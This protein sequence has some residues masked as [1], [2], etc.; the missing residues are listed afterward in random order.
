MGGSRVRVISRRDF[1]KIMGTAAAALGLSQVAPHVKWA[2]GALDKPAVIWLE[3]QDCAGCTES[4]LAILK[5]K[6]V[7]QPDIRDVVLDLVEIKYHETIMAGAGYVAEGALENAIAEGGYLLVVEGSI[8]ATDPRFLMVAGRPVEETFAE[9]AQNAAAIVA[10]GACACFG[11]IC[12]AC[13]SRGQ[14]VGYWVDRYKISTP[15]INLPGCPVKPEWFFG[16]VVNF[17]STGAP[18]PMDSLHRPLDYFSQTVHENCPRRHNFMSNRF[19]V[20]WNDPTQKDYCLFLQGCKGPQSYS[21]CPSLWW[22]DGA[23]WCI[24][25]GA[26]CSGCTEPKLGFFHIYGEG[27]YPEQGGPPPPPPPSQEYTNADCVVCHS[28]K[29]QGHFGSNCL[30]CHPGQKT[31]HGR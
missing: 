28:D 16:T 3:G 17:L 7:D 9:A 1:L 30:A 8:P 13:A 14:G 29:Q 5:G 10:I 22:N 27:E 6:R 19:L 11:G 15:Y 24:G 12:R 20:D 2:R 23:N 25:A 21:N 4:V 18:P 26:P 31:P